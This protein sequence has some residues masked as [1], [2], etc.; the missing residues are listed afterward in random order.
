MA[1]NGTRSFKE[2]IES[3]SGEGEA[4]D[5]ASTGMRVMI[6]I[7]RCSPSSP[8]HEP[9]KIRERGRD[10]H[11][12]RTPNVLFSSNFAT[13]RRI[14]LQALLHS[15]R[16]YIESRIC[17]DPTKRAIASVACRLRVSTTH[18][19]ARVF[20]QPFHVLVKVADNA[21]PR[22]RPAQAFFCCTLVVCATRHRVALLPPP[23]KS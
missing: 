1:I 14:F 11:A 18:G 19:N 21:R 20:L 10:C 17:L 12:Y 16:R 7:A 4:P 2:N 3:D 22:P 9:R 23:V 5:R 6:S 15:F 8:R 13:Q